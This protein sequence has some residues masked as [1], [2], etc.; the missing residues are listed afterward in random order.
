M[1]EDDEL[2][3]KMPIIQLIPTTSSI[4]ISAQQTNMADAKVGD[5][6][7]NFVDRSNALRF[8]FNNTDNIE[9]ESNI[10]ITNDDNKLDRCECH[11]SFQI[12]GT[13]NIDQASYELYFTGET[14]QAGSVIYSVEIEQIQDI[15]ANDENMEE[16]SPSIFELSKSHSKSDVN[17]QTTVNQHEFNDGTLSSPQPDYSMSDDLDEV[18]NIDQD[19]N[20]STLQE[21]HSDKKSNVKGSF[22]QQSNQNVDDNNTSYVM[23]DNEDANTSSSSPPRKVLLS[24]SPTPSLHSTTGLATTP[25]ISPR[26]PVIQTSGDKH[27]LVA[28][29]PVAMKPSTSRPHVPVPTTTTTAVTAAVRTRPTVAPPSAGNRNGRPV[30]LQTPPSWAINSAGTGTGTDAGTTNNSSVMK[31]ISKQIIDK[32][33]IASTVNKKA[34]P[35]TRDRLN[36]CVP[37]RSVSHKEENGCTLFDF[38]KKTSVLSMGIG[39]VRSR[40]FKDGACPRLYIELSVGS[41]E[42]CGALYIPWVENIIDIDIEPIIWKIYKELEITVEIEGFLGLDFTNGIEVEVRLL[43]SGER[44]IEHCDPKYTKT[45]KKV[46]ELKSIS[47]SSHAI[48]CELFNNAFSTPGTGTANVTVPTQVEKSKGNSPTYKDNESN[49]EVEVG[50]EVDGIESKFES[51]FEEP[52]IDS[53]IKNIVTNVIKPLSDWKRPDAV[54]T[55]NGLLYGYLQGFVVRSGT[56]KLNRSDVVSVEISLLPEGQKK[57]IKGVNVIKLKNEFS[58]SVEWSKPFSFPIMWSYQQ[59]L[60]G[61][62]KIT[63]YTEST[64]GDKDAVTKKTFLGTVLIDLVSFASITSSTSS[65]TASK[66]ISSLLPIHESSSVVRDIHGSPQDVAVGEFVL[67]L[68]WLLAG[69]CFVPS[70]SVTAAAAVSNLLRN[71]NSSDVS[72]GNN[73]RRDSVRRSSQEGVVVAA[74]AVVNLSDLELCCSAK[75]TQ[76]FDNTDLFSINNLNLCQGT[77]P[78]HVALG[79]LEIGDVKLLENIRTSGAPTLLKIKTGNVDRVSVIV[80]NSGQLLFETTD[81]LIPTSFLLE[82]ACPVNISLWFNSAFICSASII[83]PREQLMSGYPITILLPLRNTNN[84]RTAILQIGFQ[85]TA[86]DKV[87]KSPTVQRVYKMKI[88]FDGGTVIDGNWRPKIEPFFECTLQLAKDLILPAGGIQQSSTLFTNATNDDATWDLSCQLS[89]PTESSLVTADPSQSS[90]VAIVCRDA[91]RL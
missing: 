12:T 73:A 21:Q 71:G 76:L 5:H 27:M 61:I 32:L 19:H 48:V 90:S 2:S 45:F 54:K 25:N 89:L 80:V 79:S 51:K 62:L 91:A 49:V 38:G 50:G 13:S 67:P 82:T 24:K 22:K 75:W 28:T 34:N 64:S 40:L 63:L 70:V 10:Y 43:A 4:Q 66:V 9:F 74:E 60:A 55:V 30:A 83:L 33:T 14:T 77:S 85:L 37:L 88:C 72:R 36:K 47:L 23:V 16:I 11:G 8:K 3:G 17:L 35:P 87:Q 52:Q 18:D 57:A 1:V 46:I 59:R 20:Q 68:G 65:T 69:F 53:P 81:V 44:I 39:D 56:V 84:E 78:L 31:D 15:V 29:T 41:Y 58:D 6:S 26:A 42:M 7:Y 86:L